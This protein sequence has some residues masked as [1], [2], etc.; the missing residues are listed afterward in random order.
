MFHIILKF[1]IFL[2]ITSSTKSEEKNLKLIIS[3]FR[4]GARRE[5][6]KMKNSSFPDKNLGLGD[7]TQIGEKAHYL[8]GKQLKN[9][10]KNFFPKK[11]NTLNFEIYSSFS[12]RTITSSISQMMGIFEL[13]DGEE[14]ENNS[15]KFYNPP[16]EKKIKK[17]DQKNALP[18]KMQIVP[19][20]NDRDNLLFESAE[21]CPKLSGLKDKA[22]KVKNEKYSTDFEPLF[23]ELEDNGYS[24]KDWFGVEHYDFGF[25]NL[26]CDWVFT[27]HFAVKEFIVSENLI[28]QCS[29]N[30]YLNDFAVFDDEN[31]FKTSS[32]NIFRLI[33]EKLEIFKGDDKA[34]IDLK[35]VF[36]S[37]HDDNVSALLLLLKPDNSNCL[38][39]QYKSKFH[40]NYIQDEKIKNEKNECFYDLGYT[41]NVIIE[42]YEQ[43]SEL[44]INIRFNGKYLK[45]TDN[46]NDMKYEDFLN[47]LKNKIDDDFY[48]NCGASFLE[49]PKLNDIYFIIIGIMVSLS[50]ILIIIVLILHKKYSNKRKSEK[51][52]DHLN[53]END[54]VEKLDLNEKSDLNEKL[55]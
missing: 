10:Y 39:E 21:A 34:E 46:S 33:L 52:V 17:I 36:L 45:L 27:R 22:Y 42:L 40:K 41:T 50:I 54:N 26:M 48:N 9:T 29:Y 35:G 1:L 11:Y 6:T 53:N 23:G 20:R 8:L 43:N 25:A 38:L 51:M 5:W 4:H 37:G 19:N 30:L 12:N 32:Y 14:I 28:E 15:E 55:I 2:K 13:G 31:I 24:S 7:L 47:L 3:T 49:E 44:L 16:F 18:K